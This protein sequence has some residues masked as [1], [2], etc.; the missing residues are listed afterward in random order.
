MRPFSFLE[1]IRRLFAGLVQKTDPSQGRFISLPARVA[2]VRVTEENALC[3]SA[4]FRAV[5]Y[6]SQT[7]ASLPWDV[8]S[9]TQ[10]GTQKLTN[11][12]IW[13]LLHS[14]PNSEMNAITFR[15]TLVAWAVS[16]GN[17]YAFIERNGGGIPTALWPIS[18]DRVSV[19]RDPETKKIYYQVSNGIKEDD[20]LHPKDVF[21]VHGLGFD[22]LQGYSVI[23]YATRS[24]ALGMAAESYGADFFANGAVSTGGL[25]H[26]KVLSE[27]AKERLRKS[28]EAV[29]SGH[30][31]RFRIPI[32]EEGMEW[33]DM[34]INPNDA[35]L[36]LTREFQIREIARWFG[37]P[38][39]KLMDLG[40]A[41]WGNIEHQSIEV[42]NDAFMPWIIRLEQEADAKL[43]RPTEMGIRTKINVRGLLR[44][45]DK[46]RAEY[47][48]IMRTIGVYT[49]N[50]IRRLE[51]MDPV[52]PEGDELLVQLNQ[53]TLRQL[54]GATETGGK[55]E[56]TWQSHKMLFSNAYDRILRRETAQ[57]E[58]DKSKIT[59]FS[60][61][62]EWFNP[63]FEKEKFRIKRDIE[64]IGLSFLMQNSPGSKFNGDLHDG[65][66]NFIDWHIED[67]RRIFAEVL[68][69]KIINF[70]DS[71][72]TNSAAKRFFEC[73]MPFFIKNQGETHANA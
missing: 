35:Q 22:G 15:E 59:D 13:K 25:K 72:R 70:Y 3:L 11:H 73:L 19:I 18:P 37:L 67:S 30:G 69:D 24:I 34:M 4:V 41:T 52:G 36:I 10:Q 40:R 38:P 63:F 45:D 48:R 64:P 14:R 47:Y 55:S 23:S 26:P 33:F 51:D 43:F 21:H 56:I 50:D 5:S 53:I 2:G 20:F 1:R 65:L 42:V 7:I 29:M 31:K 9:E 46:S 28:V 44:G 71:E 17:G 39:H 54:V 66:K 68:S 8:I 6:I 49:T 16:R 27:D 12:P 62:S 60:A 57:F 32:F 61:F 58:R